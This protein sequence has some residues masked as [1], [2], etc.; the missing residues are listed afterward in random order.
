MSINISWKLTAKVSNS[1]QSYSAE[2]SESTSSK[3]GDYFIKEES[4]LGGSWV[5]QK[6]VARSERR[7]YTIK[8]ENVEEIQ[9]SNK[10]KT[11][12]AQAG[13][14]NSHSL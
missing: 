10:V 7:Y 2:N 6:R 8:S 14:F 11:F 3:Q 9:L 4:Y 12:E 13:K 5:C 1:N